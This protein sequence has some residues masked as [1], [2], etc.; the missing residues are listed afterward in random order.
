MGIEK[1]HI[2]GKLDTKVRFGRGPDGK[3]RVED[4]AGPRGVRPE[5]IAEERP[6][7]APDPRPDV[8]PTVGPV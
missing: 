7:Q 8:P 5:T 6:P 1:R 2:P 4:P 3:L